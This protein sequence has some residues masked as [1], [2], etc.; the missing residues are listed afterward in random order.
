[1]R[2][3]ATTIDKELYAQSRINTE[4]LS[5]VIGDLQYAVDDCSRF[6]RLLSKHGFLAPIAEGT[7]AA[8]VFRWITEWPP[9]VSS[10]GSESVGVGYFVP[11]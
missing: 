5:E 7:N 4:A 2:E 9:P 6:L 8:V 10:F 3:A 11:K 1:M